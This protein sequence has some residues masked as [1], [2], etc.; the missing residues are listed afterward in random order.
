MDPDTDT[1]ADMDADADATGHG[2]ATA[3]AGP[4]EGTVV[5]TGATGRLG[6]AVVAHLREAGYRTV[7]VSRSGTSDPVADGHVRAD[8]TDPGDV[9]GALTAR[10]VPDAVVHMGTPSEPGH[11]PDPDTFDG[12]VSTTYNVLS[13]AAALG[14]DRVVVASSLAAI[15]STFQPEPAR[16]GSLPVDETHPL[17]AHD[18]YGLGKRAAEVAADGVA[19]APDGPSVVS[20]RFPT[21]FDGAGLEDVLR[22]AD[23]RRTV[24]GLRESGQFET[25][26]DTLFCWLHVDDAARAVG[27][28]VAA[29][30]AGHEPLW[31][32]APDTTVDDPTADLVAHYPDATVEGSFEGREPLVD[33]SRAREVLGWEPTVRRR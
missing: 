32:S 8:C 19:R 20:L 4:G 25:A 10:G 31:L 27:R 3:V 30:V 15:G 9:Y 1:D 2:D 28:A 26:R 29:E 21:V 13:A 14:I 5:V 7:G 33:D 12:Q 11:R 23:G 16:V 6:P 24:A 17:T 18:P 22:A